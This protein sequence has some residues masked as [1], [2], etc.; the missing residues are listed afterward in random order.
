MSRGFGRVQWGCLTAIWNHERRG[1][2]P[3]TFD[4][5]VDIYKIKADKV[6]TRWISDAQ[7]VAVKRALAGLQRQARVVGFRAETERVMRWRTMLP[8]NPIT[9]IA[10]CCARAASGHAAATPPSSVMNSRR[11]I[12]SPRRRARGMIPGS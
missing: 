10:P 7:H 3:T 1:E 12:R 2:Q 9:G 11:F 5:A 6:G 4:I 8:R